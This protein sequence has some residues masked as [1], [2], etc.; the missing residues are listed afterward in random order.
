MAA[1]RSAISYPLHATQHPAPIPHSSYSF[2]VPLSILPLF[3]YSHES[4]NRAHQQSTQE[5]HFFHPQ[6]EYQFNP[7][8]FLKP[9]KEGAF[10]GK[11]EEIRPFIEEAFEAI[12]HVPFPS[13]IKISI[14]NAEQ[15]RIIAPN[16]DT[17]GLSINRRKDGLLSE[18]FVL[19]D[20]L[21]RVMLTL[22]HEL[23]HVLTPMLDDPHDEEAKAYAFSLAWMNVVQQN[24]IGNLGDSFVTENPAQNGLHNLAFGFVSGLLQQGKQ[25][26]NVYTEIVQKK[27]SV[28]DAGMAVA[29]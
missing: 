25:A 4:L 17:I 10:V 21:A 1:E 22:G 20:S 13:D 3:S 2:N 18:I 16:P 6:R 28:K 7:D 8:T 11:A 29:F 12:Y 15:F 23:G 27:L 19:N 5:Y 9:G 24:N 14:C 26:W